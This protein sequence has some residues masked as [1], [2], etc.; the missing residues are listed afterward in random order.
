MESSEIEINHDPSMYS[1]VLFCKTIP[2]YQ[3]DTPPQEQSQVPPQLRIHKAH[4]KFL[5]HNTD[6]LLPII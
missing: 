1:R 4:L 5:S 3:Q 6:F 2:P